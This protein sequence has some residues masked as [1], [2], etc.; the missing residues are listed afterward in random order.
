MHASSVESI[1]T[2][3]FSLPVFPSELVIFYLHGLNSFV[4]VHCFAK[5]REEHQWLVDRDALLG[6]LRY[7]RAA[8]DGHGRQVECFPPFVRG[9]VPEGVRVG[10]LVG[11]SDLDPFEAGRGVEEL[12]VLRFSIR[13]F[14]APDDL[15][16]GGAGD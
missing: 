2:E 9:V 11:F 7:A 6:E 16:V 15:S 4:G 13:V 5:R 1:S 10:A 14:G 3:K 8:K 12:F